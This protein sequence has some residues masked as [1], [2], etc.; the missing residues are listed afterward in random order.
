MAAS[1]IMAKYEISIMKINNE[2]NNNN[3]NN[4]NMK[5]RK[6]RNISVINN[7]VIEISIMA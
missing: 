7:G 6:W 3:N 2:N 1:I 5:C 4:E